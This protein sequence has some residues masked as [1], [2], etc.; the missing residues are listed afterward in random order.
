VVVAVVAVVAP[1]L[2]AGWIG[3]IDVACL[4]VGTGT[5]LATATLAVAVLRIRGIAAVVAAVLVV[6]AATIFSISLALSLFDAYDRAALIATNLVTLAFIAGLWSR[7]GRPRPLVRLPDLRELREGARAHPYLAA[8]LL[9]LAFATGIEAVLALGVVPNNYDSMFYHLSRVAY[10]M[11]GDSVLPFYGGS[12]FQLQHPP[13][14]EI[15][16]GWTMELTRGDRFAQFVQWLAL[17]GL[18]CVIYAGARFL[19]FSRAGSLFAAAVFGTLPLPVL[20]HRAPRTTSWPPSSRARPP[21]SW[22]APWRRNGWEKRSSERSHWAS[23]SAP[24]EPF[25][26]RFPAWRWSSRRPC[27]GGGRRPGSSPRGRQS[28]PWRCWRSAVRPTSRR[29]WTRAAPSARPGP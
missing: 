26:S 15:L 29:L 23:P 2:P 22:F 12:I 17:A 20:G 10:W 16:Q 13:N 4:V 27:G 28:W 5:L 6:A 21:C 3:P 18:V 19:S 24:R 14:A 7:G 9:A 25:C 11:Q 1:F 8:I